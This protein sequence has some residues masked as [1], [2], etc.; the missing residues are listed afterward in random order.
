M[1]R[2]L[3]VSG[4]DSGGGA[5]LQAD[6][7]TLM[8]CG[9]H[10]LSAVTAVTAQ[11]SREVSAFW[12]V[13]VTLVFAQLDAT[14]REIGADAVKTG[15]LVSGEVVRAV[16]EAVGAAPAGLPLVVDPVLRSTGGHS[17]LDDA[18][19][20]ALREELLPLATVVTPNLAEVEALTGWVVHDEEDLVPAAAA[21]LELGP[22]WVLLTG[23]H[24]PGEAVDLLTDGAHE[25]VLRS[26]RLPGVHARGTGCTLASALAA[27][28]ARGEEMPVAA[29]RAKGYVSGAIAGGFA[30]G[31]GAGVLDHGWATR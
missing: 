22:R 15:A 12:P 5:G 8:A 16:A 1:R 11:T 17:L 10:G 28:L 13:P 24:L 20:L 26:P 21:V 4:S 25:Y 9:V 30:V 2:V 3:A 19:L 29:R 7:R 6:L 14:L 27:F 23:G 18:G 31:P